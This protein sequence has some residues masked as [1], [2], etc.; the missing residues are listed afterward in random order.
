[1]TR[2]SPGVRLRALLDHSC[3]PCPGAFNGLVGRAVAAAGFESAYVSGG[4]I[5]AAAGVP[6]IG[7]LSLEHFCRIIREVSAASGLPVIADADT[8]FGEEQMVRRAVIEYA[9]AG[10]AALHIE[11]QVFPKRCGHLEGKQLIP[12]EQAAEK[13]AWASRAAGE[14]GDGSTIVCARTD[15]A[16]VDGLDAALERAR[17]YV[18]AGAGM[19]FPEGLRSEADF[20]AFARAMGKLGDKRPYLLANMTEFGKTPMIPLARFEELGYDVVI[21]P[22]STLRLALGA[23]VPALAELRKKGTL[24][25]RLDAMQTRDELYGLLGYEPLEAWETPAR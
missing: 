14:V 4:A 7:L 23:I 5:S 16:G 24:E 19:I 10:A 17:A 1:M 18:Q 21:Y 22:V 25:G 12:L 6:D 15:A 9:Q 2:T 11:D 8:G 20:G 3:T 13:I